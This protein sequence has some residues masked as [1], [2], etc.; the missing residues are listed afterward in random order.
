[1]S[2]GQ[3]PC[4][5]V[6][7]GGPLEP[8]K[9]SAVAQQYLDKKTHANGVGEA[10]VCG[11][12]SP[13]VITSRTSGVRY[14]QSMERVSLSADMQNVAR[15]V[16]FAQSMENANLPTSLQSHKSGVRCIQAGMQS[17][18]RGVIVGQSMEKVNLPTSLRDPASGLP[19]LLSFSLRRASRFLS[20]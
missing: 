17:T 15:G 6:V 19:C 12:S 10:M 7:A 9:K 18:A 11:R 4:G 5:G 3:A 1:M 20:S 16:I 2:G 13:A 14:I 8:R